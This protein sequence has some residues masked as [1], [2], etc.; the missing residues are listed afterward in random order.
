MIEPNIEIVES[1]Q[2]EWDRHRGVLYVHNKDTGHTILRI[3]NLPS[4]SNKCS[5]GMG[6]MDVTVG[7]GMRGVS[8]PFPEQGLDRLDKVKP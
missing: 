5:I 6:C 7:H 1:C 4:Q 2:L 8:M 3:S